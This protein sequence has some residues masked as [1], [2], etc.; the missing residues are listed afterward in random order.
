[1][2]QCWPVVLEGNAHPKTHGTTVSCML[3]N[4]LMR[5]T[6]TCVISTVSARLRSLTVPRQESALRGTLSAVIGLV[7][8]D[9]TTTPRVSRATA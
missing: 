7:F 5:S 1:M 8:R 2:I 9:S 3:T 6:R 4:A